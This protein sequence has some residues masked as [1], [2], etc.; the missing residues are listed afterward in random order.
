ML[1]NVIFPIDKKN[2]KII[3]KCI[4]NKTILNKKNIPWGGSDFLPRLSKE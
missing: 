1:I 2:A 3:Q 4:I